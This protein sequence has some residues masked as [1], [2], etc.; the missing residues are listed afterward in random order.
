MEGGGIVLAIPPLPPPPLFPLP[1]SR[2]LGILWGVLH[3]R[4][5]LDEFVLLG[6]KVGYRS[7]Q[8]LSFYVE[9]RNLSDEIYAA[10]TGVVHS[11]NPFNANQFLPGDGRSVYFGIEYQF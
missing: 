8:G 1:P 11:I 10:T 9:G 2:P 5:V 7:K 3:R 6:F 4:H